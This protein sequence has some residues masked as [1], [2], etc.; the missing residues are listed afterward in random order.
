MKESFYY[1]VALLFGTMLSSDLRWLK[2]YNVNDWILYFLL[3]LIGL[4]MGAD[5]NLFINLKK[6]TPKMLIIPIGTIV[7]TYLTAICFTFLTH[8]LTLKE[9][10]LIA[11]GF[12]FY[13]LSSNLI[14]SSVP[15]SLGLIVFFT[16][17]FREFFVLLFAKQIVFIFGKS[18]LIP[19]SAS[20]SDMC[21][22]VISSLLGEEAVFEA[23]F[24]SMLLTVLVPMV[25]Q[26]I[27]GLNLN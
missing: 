13:S 6:I 16:N 18:S 10:L 5:K 3:F 21:I 27:L 17:L 19:I 2:N 20:A 4:A 15:G 22:P 14:S 9:S 1:T 12:G 25:I 24:N 26:L 11:S 8:I 23:L 7:G